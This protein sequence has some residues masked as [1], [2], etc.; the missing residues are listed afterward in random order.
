MADLPLLALGVAVFGITL[1]G[2]LASAGTWFVREYFRQVDAG[3]DEG[4]AE[5]GS[6]R[7]ARAER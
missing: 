1:I 2:A 7:G 5:S 4:P 3:P 6:L